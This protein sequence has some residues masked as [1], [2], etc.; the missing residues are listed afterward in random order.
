M[1]VSKQEKG[2]LKKMLFEPNPYGISIILDWK[3]FSLLIILLLITFFIGWYVNGFIVYRR[4]KK[5]VDSG[6]LEATLKQRD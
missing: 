1:I 6:E 2:G 5:L 4:I 3:F